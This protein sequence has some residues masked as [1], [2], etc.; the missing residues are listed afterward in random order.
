MQLETP[1]ETVEA[2]ADLAEGTG[3][4]VILN[5]APAQALSKKLLQK[6]SILTPNETEAEIL[7]GIKVTDDDSCRRAAEILLKQGVKTVIIT[8]AAS[9]FVATADSSQ[10]VPGFEV[11]PVDTTAAGDTF[12]GAPA[13]ALAEGTSLV[14]AVRF[15]N[16]AAAIS[17]TRM[18]SAFRAVTEGDRD[19]RR[20]AERSAT[21]CRERPRPKASFH[22]AR[23]GR[24]F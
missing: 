2:A 6:I 13:V 22:L 15:A 8:L 7:T 20:N 4:L 23:T 24:C 12:N 9:A 10:L 3:A 11:K 21:G 19:F 1:L 18:G 16:A 17:V 14:E 5:P